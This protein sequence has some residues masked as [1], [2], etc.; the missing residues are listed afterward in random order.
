MRYLHP[1]LAGREPLCPGS[2]LGKA[3]P[4]KS[5]TGV[6]WRIYR[7]REGRRGERI[8]R[9]RIRNRD[10]L[11]GRKGRKR[12]STQRRKMRALFPFQESVNFSN[13]T[14]TN[15]PLGRG[16]LVANPARQRTRHIKRSRGGI[17]HGMRRENR[18]RNRH[19]NRCRNIR[20]RWF[21]NGGRGG[22]YCSRCFRHDA[23]KKGAINTKENKS[24]GGHDAHL[25][26]LKTHLSQVVCGKPMGYVIN[27]N[28]L[29]DLHVMMFESYKVFTIGS[30]GGGGDGG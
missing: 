11:R 14:Q 5:Q 16:S 3:R 7:T 4:K 12:R 8:N 15:C 17:G 9:T 27:S 24:P 30:G 6:C 20:N 22:R 23:L 10:R 25:R 19:E 26:S 18:C 29:E 21:R 28:N 2:W 1:Y 13:K